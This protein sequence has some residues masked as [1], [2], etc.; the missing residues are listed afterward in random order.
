MGSPYSALSNLPPSAFLFGFT[1][2][3]RLDLALAILTVTFGVVV[4]TSFSLGHFRRWYLK[5]HL[6]LAILFW[7]QRALMFWLLMMGFGV[8]V[9]H[10]GIGGLASYCVGAGLLIFAFV[11]GLTAHHGPF[12]GRWFQGIFWT[13][14]NLGLWGALLTGIGLWPVV[15]P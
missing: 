12:R 3:G 4:Y 1:W 10:A 5:V 6:W 9:S 8:F 2:F 11:L 15:G 7:V 13:H 14:L